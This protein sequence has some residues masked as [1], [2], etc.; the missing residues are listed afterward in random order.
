MTQIP[1]R[2]E[3][4]PSKLPLYSFSRD[5]GETAI[6]P[7]IRKISTS[8]READEDECFAADLDGL[9]V[10]PESTLTNHLLLAE[11]MRFT[12]EFH[13][14]KGKEIC[15]SGKDCTKTHICVR[16]S[17]KTSSHT[18]AVYMTRDLKDISTVFVYQLQKIYQS[19]NI[20]SRICLPAPGIYKRLEIRRPHKAVAIAIYMSDAESERL[21]NRGL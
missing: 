18:L 5:T 9:A 15:L 10:A 11:H 19:P 16:F 14:L 17:S 20:N 1:S 21:Y 6:D 4:P 2:L 12:L 3:E 7:R 13:I 8:T